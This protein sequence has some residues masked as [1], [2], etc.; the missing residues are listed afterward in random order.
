MYQK[1]CHFIL[2]YSWYPLKANCTLSNTKHP[3]PITESSQL[4]KNQM[5]PY[6]LVLSKSAKLCSSC[7][8]IAV[9]VM[10]C[11]VVCTPCQS[12]DS[13]PISPFHLSLRKVPQYY[14]VEV[15]KMKP[16]W[17]WCIVRKSTF[18]RFFFDVILDEKTKNLKILFRRKFFEK[19][20]P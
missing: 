12:T 5:P 17:T 14:I 10:C 8:P 2:V 16:C 3:V 18:F 1:M 19:S 15:I 7:Q 4:K 6:C 9:A 20:K 11:A 13:S